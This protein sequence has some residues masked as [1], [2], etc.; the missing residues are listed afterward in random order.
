V[1][2]PRGG[3]K[4]NDG[5]KIPSVTEVLGRFKDSTALIQ[6]AHKLGKAGIDMH[7]EVK[8]AAS[9]GSSLHK[10]IEKGV[11]PT[12]PHIG[13]LYATWRGLGLPV[14]HHEVTLVSERL[15]TGG[16][17][18]AVSP[19]GLLPGSLPGRRIYDWKTSNRIYQDAVIQVA[20]YREI[21]NEKHPTDRVEDAVI[22]RIDKVSPG[23]V[24]M[25]RVPPE[26]LADATIM[27]ALYRACYDKSQELDKWLK[28]QVKKT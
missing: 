9:I 1:G 17:I 15:K 5:T 27:F 8:E 10:S 16:T 19:V 3:Y 18:D 6:W 12:D 20:A 22:V 7:K 11:I 14:E 28:S 26:V 25:L 2:R 4:L 24:D 23:K 13:A 21:W